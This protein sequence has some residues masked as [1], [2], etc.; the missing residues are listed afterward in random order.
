VSTDGSITP[1]DA[2]SYSSS[3][4]IEQLQIVESIS[5]P[6]VLEI[7]EP[8]S[9]EVMEIRKLLNLTIDEMEL[10]VR[11][12]NCLQAAGIKYIYELVSKE[13]NEM[14]KYKNFGR[15]SLTEL[16]EKLD[17]M[18]LTFGMEVDKYLKEEV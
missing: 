12:H 17:H 2:V 1:Q 5:K 13:E 7:S 15:K 14:L 4:L 8:I 10:S 3:I 16:V 18:G 9:E 6:E 11:S